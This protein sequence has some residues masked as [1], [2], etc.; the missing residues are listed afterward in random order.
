[1]NSLQTTDQESNLPATSS[2]GQ[3]VEEQRAIA[4]VKA[5]LTAAAYMPRNIKAAIRSFAVT[6]ERKTFAEKA[7][8]EF[9]RGG[10]V[11]TGPSIRFAEALA[12]QWG[13]IDYGWRVIEMRKASSV[14]LCHAWDTQSNV[15]RVVQ[16]ENPH[17]RTGKN[18]AILTDPRDIYE[19]DANQ[20]MRRLRACLLGLLPADIVE[21]GLEICEKTLKASFDGTPETIKKLADAFLDQFGVTQSQIEARIQRHIGAMTA[22]NYVSLRNIFASLRDGMSTPETWFKEVEAE[23]TPTEGQAVLSGGFTDSRKPSTKKASQASANKQPAAKK[24]PEKE[25]E[26]ETK[27]EPEPEATAQP[28]AKTEPERQPEPEPETEPKPEVTL[29]GYI[30]NPDAPEYEEEEEEDDD[31]QEEPEPVN[32][33]PSTPVIGTATTWA[34]L[35]QAVAAAL[36][37]FGDTPESQDQIRELAFDRASYLAENGAEDIPSVT[38]D[39]QMFS[40]FISSKP[41]KSAGVAAWGAFIRSQ[42]YADLPDVNRKALA[43]RL[44]ALK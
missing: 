36:R 35:K 11:I 32:P 43:D 16:F 29:E 40:M 39:A 3:S 42:A 24:E 27:A 31:Q 17:R 30:E 5:M 9:S 18:S 20:A 34:T 6:C 22:G 28:N 25:P 23:Q 14:I 12:L 2:G 37:E 26:P 38:A 4:E 7:T 21:E 15:R 41:T 19:N 1:M 10:T 13:N 33:K 8:Y 44:Q